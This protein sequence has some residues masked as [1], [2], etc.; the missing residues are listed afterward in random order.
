MMVDMGRFSKMFLEIG[1]S[2]VESFKMFLHARS[3]S[4]NVSAIIVS[5]NSPVSLH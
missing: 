3:I 1:L 4:I 2:V 5:V